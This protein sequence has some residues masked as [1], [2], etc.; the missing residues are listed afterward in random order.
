MPNLPS[1]GQTNWG[2]PLNAAVNSISTETDAV[3]VNLSSHAANSPA[4]PHGDRAF[5]TSQLSP[6]TNG[7][8]AANGYVKLNSSG[9]I[10]AALVNGTS[11]TGG[12]YSGIYDAVTMFGAVPNTNADQSSAIQS[13]LNA[14]G[15]AG[16]GIVYI[17]PG[18]FSLGTYLVMKSNTWLNMSPG[19]ILQR[20]VVSTTPAYIISNILV[21]SSGTPATN[22]KIT[23]GKLDA[24]GSNA[25]TGACTPVFIFQS[26]STT[27][28][29]LTIASVYNNPAIELNGSNNTIVNNVIFTGTTIAGTPSVP[30]VRLNTS[31][32]TTTPSGL[33]GGFYDDLS[34]GGCSAT[35][36][37]RPVQ[38]NNGTYD[39]FAGSDKTYG[40]AP[41]HENIYIAGNSD[42]NNT[43]TG[44]Y[45]LNPNWFTYSILGNNFFSEPDKY[46]WNDLRPLQNSFAGTVTNQYPPQYMV[47][48]GGIVHVF[49]VVQLPSSSYNAIQFAHIPLAPA[50]AVSTP[51]LTINTGTSNLTNTPFITIDTSGNMTF[52]DLGTG[53]G[54]TNVFMDFSYPYSVSGSALITS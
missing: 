40:P 24:Y 28:E 6:I 44:R 30:A 15:A 50:H 7:V 20:V 23:G 10:P 54:G 42:L 33:S 47:T 4:D 53:L 13:A 43:S 16:G 32:T 21:S 27:I 36:C 1:D 5:T 37:F 26:R 9:F 17:G 41:G 25:V 31:S 48:D 11:A 52:H 51:A 14:A 2:D 22:V 3:Q 12:M 29:D 45:I 46:V 19:T 18:T 38:T 49:G 35:N 34:V 39:Y 8:N